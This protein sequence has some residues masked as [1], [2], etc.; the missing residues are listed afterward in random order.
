ML[1]AAESVTSAKSDPPCRRGKLWTWFTLFVA[2]LAL[3]AAIAPWTFS[4][5]ALYEEVSGQINRSMGLFVATEGRA[6]LTLL[7]RPHITLNQVFF[8][9]PAK[10]VT[11][12]AER[13]RGN[14]SLFRLLAGRLELSEIA[15][16]S[17]RITVDL[18][19]KPVS[20]A[21]A[22]ARAAAAQPSSP[23]A[24]KA[25][26]E[27]LGILYVSAGQAKVRQGGKEQEFSN[28][29]GALNW[30]K[31][32]SPA[33]FAGG[34]SWKGER[35]QALLWV[36]RPGELLRGEATPTTARLDSGN[37]HFEAEGLG[38]TGTKPRFTGRISGSTPTLRQALGLFDAQTPLPGP[39]EHI[40]LAAQA[41]VSPREL[42]L[43]NLRLFASDNEFQGSLVLRQE[44]DRTIV[45]GALSSNF[46]SVRPM[47]ADLPP[48]TSSDGQWS[49]DSFE[50]PN[51]EGAD[52]D[53]HVFAAHA[54]LARISLDDADLSLKLRGGRLDIALNEG[55]AYKGAIKAHAI[56]AA[57]P[58]EGLE[59]HF[60]AQMAG[61]DA[62]MLGW[63]AAE[64]S[65]TSGNLDSSASLGGVGDSVAQIMRNL[66]GRATISLT[67]GAIDGI[68]LERALR[69]LDKTPLSSAIDI[70]S[71]RTSFDRAG[72]TIQVEKG[73]ATIEDGFATGPGFSL[74]F[75][76]ST[77]IAD[78]SLAIK[79]VAIEA[80]T[81]G[82]PREKGLQIGFDI[83]GS[84]DDLNFSPDAQSFIKRSGA[85]APLFPNKELP[86]DSEPTSRIK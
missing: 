52:V 40:Q 36:A 14:L 71:G 78:R 79:A 25:D 20:P 72:A 24:A 63:D 6:T 62:G 64:R 8:A 48:M 17:P 75:N 23:E 69:R 45:Q 18:D 44:E 66:D 3:A 50:L 77:R 70:R 65:H 58:G 85:A 27:T 46:L 4:S 2:A 61:V 55:K 82:K 67:Q 15:L 53:L 54:R 42:Q 57:R 11:I 35:W 74:A 47:T 86:A 73:V 51:L 60:T 9:E 7:P 12:H 39:I 34:F 38:Q 41:S 28:I 26:Q 56:F 43:T 1:Q 37:F 83:S 80:D 13:V 30:P 84:W 21:G 10:A 19:R 22:A 32:G 29:D 31:V 16:T 59:C 76:G 49:R 81:A 5:K 68:N 33:T